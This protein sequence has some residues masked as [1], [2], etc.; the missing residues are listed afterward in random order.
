MGRAMV[1]C[2]CVHE[3][4][5]RAFDMSFEPG[6][7]SALHLMLIVATF[8]WPTRRLTL[9]AVAVV[10]A[11]TMVKMPVVWDVNIW[12]LQ[13][14]SVLLCLGALASLRVASGRETA[15]ADNGEIGDVVAEAWALTTRRQLALFYLASGF[16]KINSSFLNYHTSCAPMFTL[17]LLGNFRVA[18]S[19]PML[20]LVAQASPLITI[21]GEM[22]LGLL[23]SFDKTKAVGVLA[24]LALHAGIALSPPPNNAVPFSVVCATRLLLIMPHGLA[25][26]AA[27][28]GRGGLAASLTAAKAA[29]A[30]AAG[31]S[32]AYAWSVRNMPA[33]AV[34]A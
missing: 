9:L 32:V 27:E 22:S 7:Q 31:T 29:A 11:E 33:E 8:A 4:V 30:A 10:M 34:T 1:R 5:G 25:S 14:D 15:S 12:T 2:W 19:Q 23:L 26:A 13:M 16:W 17:T 20:L 3:F 6:A 18:L 24:A 28:M 21:G